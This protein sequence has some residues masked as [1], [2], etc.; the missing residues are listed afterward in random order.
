MTSGWPPAESRL[1]G[2]KGKKSEGIA[3]RLGLAVALLAGALVAACATRSPED[4]VASR[5]RLATMGSV[6]AA[7]P[8]TP[9]SPA[10]P[11]FQGLVGLSA[12]DLRRL[13]GEPDFRRQEPLA[14]FWQY[15][16]A[17]CVLDLFLY[18]DGRAYHVV[19][20]DTRDRGFLRVSQSNCYG[21][22]VQA[23]SGRLR[24]SVLN[25]P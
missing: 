22:L 7:A 23:R 19:H 16:T 18:S 5:V 10:A 25:H 8:A 17:D 12:A 15:R 3:R 13:L 11:D 24:Q 14:E 6:V 9:S 1:G 20:A 2:A 4:G 21:A